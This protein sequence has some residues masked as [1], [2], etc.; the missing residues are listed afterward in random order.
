MYLIFRLFVTLPNS[1]AASLDSDAMI[2]DGCA[3]T[4]PLRMLQE[5]VR[6]PP[7]WS[8]HLAPLQ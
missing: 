3:T 8:V 6:E 1:D 5:F 7:W 2:A 4:R